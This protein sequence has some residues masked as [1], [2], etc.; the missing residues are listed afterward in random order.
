M[1]RKGDHS[2]LKPL[3]DLDLNTIDKP[4]TLVILHYNRTRIS[5]P[6]FKEVTDIADLLYHH[7]STLEQQVLSNH[8][9]WEKKANQQIVCFQIKKEG[10]GE[11]LSDGDLRSNILLSLLRIKG[12]GGIPELGFRVDVTKV[13]KYVEVEPYYRVIEREE[14][15]RQ[16][17][18]SAYL[19]FYRIVTSNRNANFYIA[20]RITDGYFMGVKV[21]G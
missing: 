16:V 20:R 21:F 11:R 19:S 4:K 7:I 15:M 5:V 2:H 3:K 14:R 12:E 9:D 18:R 6:L 10:G 1:I 13:Y 17:D 8:S